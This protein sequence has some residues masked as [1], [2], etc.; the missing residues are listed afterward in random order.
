MEWR[1]WGGKEPDTKKQ[2]SLWQRW[3]EVCGGRISKETYATIS[4][5]PEWG[6]GVRNCSAVKPSSEKGGS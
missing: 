4:Q 3:G 2:K 1:D 6:V 5:Y